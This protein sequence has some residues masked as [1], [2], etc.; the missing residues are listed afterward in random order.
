MSN[1]KKRLQEFEAL[2]ALSIILLLA[3]HSDVFSLQFFGIPLDPISHFVGAFLLGSFFFLAGYFHE[4]SLQKPGQTPRSII[5][6]KFLRIFPPYWMALVLFIFVMGYSL[7]K[8]DLWTYLLNL[9]FIFSPT[10]VKQMLTLWYISVV[11]GYYIIFGILIHYIKS[12][13][14]L[15]LWS[16]VLF[17][18]AYIL[19]T[20]TGLLDGRFFEYYFIFLAGVYFSR[21]PD[22]RE[23]LI[24]VIFPYKI[25]AALLGVFLFRLALVRGYEITH[26]VY[27]LTVDVYILSWVWMWLGIFKTSIGEWRIWSPV[28]TASFFAYLYHRPIW[29]ALIPLL[30]G[31][32]G[33]S[34]IIFQFIPGSV[35]VL[36][37][38][39]FLQNGYDTALRNMRKVSFLNPFVSGL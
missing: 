34:S 33:M 26:G 12:G 13:G 29:Y 3:L 22:V 6:S 4:A 38:C 37:L 15:F 32:L 20:L 14:A 1:G 21:Y 25:A 7:K 2:R 18:G 17:A 11:M 30:A 9:Q 19:H 10:F 27:L 35:I 8:F 16:A 39:Y 24:R 5:T 23:K 28:S 31:R 36:I